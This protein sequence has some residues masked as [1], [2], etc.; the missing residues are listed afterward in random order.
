M[1][2][3]ER[4][5]KRKKT[6]PNGGSGVHK[7]TRATLLFPEPEEAPQRS[8]RGGDVFQRSMRRGLMTL[9]SERKDWPS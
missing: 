4:G 2:H 5:S 3:Q 8:E 7:H 9:L 6:P 1:K